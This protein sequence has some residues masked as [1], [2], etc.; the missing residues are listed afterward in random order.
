MLNPPTY[1]QSI[2][3]CS[4]NVLQQCPHNRAI[5]SVLT[6]LR[7][8]LHCV[9]II[10][11]VPGLLSPCS[12]ALPTRGHGPTGARRSTSCLA[13]THTANDSRYATFSWVKGH[14][15][16]Y[17]RVE[18]KLPNVSLRFYSHIT[19]RKPLL[20]SYYEASSSVQDEYSHIA[21]V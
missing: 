9:R 2:A 17:T 19:T 13:I 18:E 12:T 15:G 5:I 7:L 20:Q 3:V 6:H 4:W 21:C 11:I 16:S 8:N 14:C 10:R 1:K